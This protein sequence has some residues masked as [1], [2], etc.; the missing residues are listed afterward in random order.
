MK[1]T[2]SEVDPSHGATCAASK[3]TSRTPSDRRASA[4]ALRVGVTAL[5]SALDV[6]LAQSDPPRHQPSTKDIGF[7]DRSAV[8]AND[9]RYA[10]V[11]GVG[12]YTSPGVTELA[13]AVRDAEDVARVLDETGWQV[14]LMTTDLTNAK[15]RP[16]TAEAIERRIRDYASVTDELDTILFYFSG[17]G[18]IDEQKNGYLCPT[19]V[20]PSPGKLETTGLSIDNVRQA[21]ASGK[22][23][24]Q[25]L[26]LDACRNI[27]GKSLFTQGYTEESLR[28]SKGLGILYATSPGKLSFEP[29][30]GDRDPDGHPIQNGLFT[31]FLLRGLRGE[32]RIN[33]D[34][35]LTFHELACW[36]D[37]TMRNY[38]LK[39]EWTRYGDQV[40]WKAWDGGPNDDILIREIGPQLLADSVRDTKPTEPSV[41]AVRNEAP[42]NPKLSK[43]LT[44]AI[45]SIR[46][47][48]S[49]SELES[50]I[51]PKLK[52]IAESKDPRKRDE[53][54]VAAAFLAQIFDTLV[55]RAASSGA[56][57]T[58][59]RVHGGDLMKLINGGLDEAKLAHDVVFDGVSMRAMCV[60]YDFVL[61][62]EGAEVS[63]TFRPQ[64]NDRAAKA[65]TVLES[66]RFKTAK[67][68]SGTPFVELMLERHKRLSNN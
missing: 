53:R 49:D 26:I 47:G 37:A 45:A 52:S 35:Y 25:I 15:L 14:S 30:E 28:A 43:E 36:V 67:D 27:P 10:V 3:L 6:A 21:L 4:I 16:D 34:E 48:A 8:R 55:Q 20:D 60:Y 22:S 66:G 33:G 5:V 13:C 62:A 50:K 11:V 32:A 63:E 64:L 29:R 9:Q 39:D 40:P 38:V 31:H 23:Q 24:K 18:F 51:R 68:F 59:A 65:K 19:N 61:A 58:L 56:R 1:R 2:N 12:S 42:A 57:D 17:H 46:A 54:L 44:D 7:F 41:A